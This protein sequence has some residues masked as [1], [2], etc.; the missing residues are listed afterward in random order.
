MPRVPKP[1]GPEGTVWFGGEVERAEL[2]LRVLGEDLD[3]SEITALMLQMPSRS[4]R[5][6]DPV[7]S[8]A[9]GKP[10]RISKLGSWIFNYEPLAE[11]TVGE[12]IATL[13]GQLPDDEELWKSLTTR[14]KVDL[15]CD[16]FVRGVNQGL[17]IAP[18]VIQLLARRNITLGIDIFAEP[19]PEQAGLLQERLK[20]EG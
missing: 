16:V 19:D 20:E 10:F 7:I 13:L 14:F 9:T 12:A 17:E 8:Q 5:K 1:T 6:G 15:I 18:A 4:R 2:C 11:E 3:P